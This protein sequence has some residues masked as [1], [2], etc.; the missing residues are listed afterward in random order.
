MLDVDWRRIE[1]TTS[2]AKGAMLADLHAAVAA[3]DA[4]DH[5]HE[6]PARSRPERDSPCL[7]DAAGED[8]RVH[9]A[10]IR[11]AVEVR[12]IERTHFAPAFSSVEDEIRH[13]PLEDRERS[14]AIARERDGI[15]LVHSRR[16]VRQRDDSITS[17]H[18]P[19]RSFQETTGLLPAPIAS[20]K[21]RLQG[22]GSEGFEDHAAL[23][24]ESPRPLP[25][26]RPLF[27]YR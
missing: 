27:L 2:P 13:A 14:A 10:Q 15:P 8:R 16:Q 20:Q 4:G 6:R 9:G 1:P 22:G 17:H 25:R 3:V 7:E 18:R 21:L 24:G 12:V 5:E 11:F 26:L 23:R 19:A